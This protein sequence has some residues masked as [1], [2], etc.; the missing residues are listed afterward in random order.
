M[1]SFVLVFATF[2]YLWDDELPR[3]LTLRAKKLQAH[4][5]KGRRLGGWSAG[6]L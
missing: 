5:W 2:A 1:Q 4:C 3:D 6:C